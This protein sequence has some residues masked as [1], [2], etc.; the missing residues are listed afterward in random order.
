MK[1]KRGQFYIFT[2]IIIITLVAGFIFV[3]NYAKRKASI[4]L[5][6]I[7]EELGIES[8]NV[9]DFGV[10]NEYNED[11]MKAL[12]ESFVKT[13]VDYA[14]EGKN[15]YF[16][17]GNTNTITTVAYQDLVEEEASINVG[18][19]I[20]YSLVIGG[21]PQEF[22]PSGNLVKIQVG[23]DEYKFTL[24]EGENFYFVISQEVEGEKHVITGSGILK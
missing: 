3:S 6:D 19:A 10:Y 12:L 22:S 18:G 17:F 7:K 15:L 16:I 13:Y 2:A 1:N 24:K 5:Y 21:E 11:Q 9:L 14:G 8:G 23:E 4:K 20:D